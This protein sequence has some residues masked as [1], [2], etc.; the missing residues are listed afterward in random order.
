[1][2]ISHKHKFIFIKTRKAAG[3]SIQI[4]LEK[5]CGPKDV[6]CEMGPHTPEELGTY[7]PRN[8][9][10]F[11]GHDHASAVLDAVGQEMWDEYFT[12]CFTRNPYD[13]IVSQFWYETSKVKSV[14]GFKQY[15]KTKSKDPE[16]GNWNYYTERGGNAIIVDYVGMYECLH[17][18]FRHICGQIGLP[19]DL[20]EELPNLKSSHRKDE[21]YRQFYSKKEKDI[22]QQ[23][24]SSKN[25]L[26]FF[27]YKF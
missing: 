16:L 22:V 27:G 1:V 24:K 14:D 4:V 17:Q 9:G 11:R 3:S 5:H 7:T 18:D 12:F 10:K 15:I 26:I 8:E 19:V 25:E 6:V 21:G 23:N 13:R 2:I 20:H